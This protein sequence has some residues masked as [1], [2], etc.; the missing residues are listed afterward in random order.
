MRF[1]GFYFLAQSVFRGLQKCNPLFI[2]EVTNI[3][4]LICLISSDYL[5]FLRQFDSS[6]PKKMCRPWLYPVEIG[7][8]SYAIPLTSRDRGAG[9]PG[10]VKCPISGTGGA[11]IRYMIP[12]PPNAVDM[13]TPGNVSEAEQQYYNHSQE[14]I[15]REAQLLRELSVAGK[16]DAAFYVHSCDFRELESVYAQWQPGLEA[17]LFC[18]ENSS[19]KSAR[20]FPYHPAGR[21]RYSIAQF[22]RSLAWVQVPSQVLLGVLGSR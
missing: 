2:L 13:N 22:R 5:D 19:H 21:L 6:V 7:G 12:V 17:G 20:K 1:P 11:N 3:E 9:F 15:L 16:M 8:I 10:F 4:F 14:Y 18:Y